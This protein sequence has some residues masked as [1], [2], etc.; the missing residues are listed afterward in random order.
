M[1]FNNLADWLSWQ[2]SSHP[3]KIDLGL[4]RV[5]AVY[6]ALTPAPPP[7]TITVAG[8]NGKGSCIALLEAI[9]RAEGYQVGSYTSPHLLRYNE[10]IRINGKNAEDAMI[11]E[12]FHRIDQA[13]K[14]VSL[15]FFEFG[16]L[17][18]L[19][20][21]T[22]AQ[23][24]I[25][26]LEVGLGGRL[27]AVNIL[28]ADAALITSIA[29]D[30]SDWLGESRDAIGLE[31]A[32]VLRKNK[33]AVMGDP[34]PPE[35][36]LQYAEQQQI[37]LSCLGKEFHHQ[38]QENCWRWI[39]N[40]FSYENLPYPALQ[41]HHQLQNSSAVLQTLHLVKDQLPVLETSIHHGLKAAR[42]PGRFQYIPGTPDLLLDVAHNPQSAASL[43]QYL[44]QTFPDRRILSIFTMMKDKD[45]ESVV[46]TM[47]SV[48]NHWYVSPLNID[49]CA[50]KSQL[51]QA[52]KN[53]SI[54]AYSNTYTHFST[55]LADARRDANDN[56]LIVIFGSFFLVAQYYSDSGTSIESLI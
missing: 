55:A 28:D 14:E 9:L 13:R 32:G 38:E 25:Q 16:T 26:L 53:C 54:E 39:S 22:T 2:E 27:D 43:A 52:F 51:E 15:S 17:T 29:I 56:D 36:I 6:Q 5:R 44:L 18:A 12:V 21:F 1:R 11:C 49:R 8:T 23:V 40:D 10:R 33:P 45:I 7:F 3:R 41:G 47:K 30:H 20:L 42:L 19:D 46:S 35:S 48:V 37:Q 50:S 4:D 24:D 34:D 31:K